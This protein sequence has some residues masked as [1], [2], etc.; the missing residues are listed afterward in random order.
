MLTIIIGSCLVVLSYFMV[1]IRIGKWW[2]P[3]WL[4]MIGMFVIVFG[5]SAPIN[6]YNEYVPR[7]EIRLSSIGLKEKNKTDIY[8]IELENGDKVY[9]SVNE[10]NKEEIKIY[11]KS[12]KVE[13]V[14]QENCETPRLV[15]YFRPIKSSIFSL[16]M[17]TLGDKY[18][19]Y[20][21][22]GSMIK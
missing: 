19:F 6:G 11:D 15:Y 4:I 9:K 10:Q 3:F 18:T 21:P 5:I 16:G 17:M 12:L 13:I 2:M 22:K 1:K 7:E 8:I 20:I 14:E